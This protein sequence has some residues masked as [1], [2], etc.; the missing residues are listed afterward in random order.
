VVWAIRTS[1]L[2]KLYVTKSERDDF[3]SSA[4]FAVFINFLDGKSNSKLRAY[5]F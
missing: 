3:F 5:F 2:M 4:I 1:F